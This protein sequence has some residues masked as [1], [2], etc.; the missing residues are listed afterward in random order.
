MTCR[1]C[2]AP[3]GFDYWPG[4]AGKRPVDPITRAPHHCPASYGKPRQTCDGCG[5]PV[6][7]Q[8]GVPIDPI[9]TN[10]RWTCPRPREDRP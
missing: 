5:L 6:A 3:I 2:A 1:T 10:H 8:G 9:G 7:F 4:I